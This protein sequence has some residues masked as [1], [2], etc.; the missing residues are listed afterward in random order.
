[1]PKKRGQRQHQFIITIVA[2]KPCTSAGALAA[3]KNAIHGGFYGS[4][5]DEQQ[6]EEFRVSN[7]IRL[8]K[9]YKQEKKS[10]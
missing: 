8:P 4:G 1:M 3:V 2:D 7:F 9:R 5:W 6:P 10:T